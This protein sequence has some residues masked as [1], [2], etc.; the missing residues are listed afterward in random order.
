MQQFITFEEAQ[1]AV[2]ERV[3]ALGTETIGL[4]EAQG[5]TL[6]EPIESRVA[7]PP[8][9][10]AA[11][12]GYAVRTSDLTEMP[13]VLPVSG[14][15]RA[16]LAPDGPIA[17]GTCVQIMTGAPVPEGTEAVVPVEWTE[18]VSETEVRIDRRPE[19]GQHV[20][21]AGKDVRVGQVIFEA[22]TI[23]TPAVAGMIASVGMERV[24][25]SRKARVALIV[26]G[27][28]LAAP[29]TA[30]KPG[31]IYNSNGPAL[32]AQVLHAGGEVCSVEHAGDDPD[33]LRA[34]LESTDGADVI[35]LSGGVSAGAYDYVR[36]VLEAF[37]VTI[38]FWKVRQRPGK[39]LVFGMQGPKPVFGLPGN[40]VSSS[41]CFD[42]YVR[43]ALGAMLG[44]RELV[45]PRY[46]AM[47]AQ[48]IK[49]AAG[50]HHFTRGIA[51]TDERAQL[52]VGEAGPQDSNLM[53]PLARANCLIHLS[54]ELDQPQAGTLVDIEWLDW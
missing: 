49:K 26:T 51:Y 27:D 4:R 41:I 12:D 21:R 22:G 47:L 6:S 36:D 25:V 1:R 10:N 7:V 20:R 43:P 30:P 23:V 45:R 54:E 42:Q 31:Q 32:A 8:F 15:L 5:R 17:P 34:V 35:V 19:D 44:R 37:G 29:G 14:R 13:R 11:M 24:A 2:L 40:P 50:L 39:P 52:M 48:G 18:A 33:A 28:E 9:D 16:G 38:H 53:G 3:S 46:R